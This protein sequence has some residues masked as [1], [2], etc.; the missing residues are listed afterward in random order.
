MT[1]DED[2]EVIEIIGLDL[3]DTKEVVSFLAKIALDYSRQQHEGEVCWGC[4]MAAVANVLAV[5]ANQDE[6]TDYP[7]EEVA[8][9]TTEV[10]LDMRAGN[11][12]SRKF[13]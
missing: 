5:L 12:N 13:H 10:I 2:G 11:D 1:E 8:R 3:A 6:Q 7:L 9:R 4:A